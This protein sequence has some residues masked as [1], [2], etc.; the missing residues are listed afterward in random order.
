MSVTN[1]Q[2]EKTARKL[3]LLGKYQ[4][5]Q[6]QAKPLIS[7]KGILKGV[8]ITEKQLKAARTSLFKS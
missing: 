1:I 7:L 3:F 6:N 5:K 4:K 8:K 2:S